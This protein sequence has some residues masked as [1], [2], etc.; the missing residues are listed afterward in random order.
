[1]AQK[2]RYKWSISVYNI[3]YI[4]PQ[5]L[6]QFQITIFLIVYHTDM[7]EKRFVFN[8]LINYMFHLLIF[9]YFILYLVYYFFVNLLSLF[10]KDRRP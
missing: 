8:D 6:H 1:M 7:Y 2:V 5:D 3:Q 10:Y 4:K 9:I